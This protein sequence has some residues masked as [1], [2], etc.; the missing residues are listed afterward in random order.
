[1]PE[2]GESADWMVRTALVVPDIATVFSL[3]GGTASAYVCYIIPAA[4]AWKLRAQIPLVSGSTFGSMAC[5]GMVVFGVLFGVLTTGATIAGMLAKQDK[6]PA[7][8]NTSWA[9]T[10]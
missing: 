3:M 1:M 8:C 6:L 10:H 9:E 4:A 7:A 2:T 5:A